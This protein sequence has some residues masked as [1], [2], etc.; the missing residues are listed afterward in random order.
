MVDVD[1]DGR[2]WDHFL[3]VLLAVHEAPQASTGFTQFELLF[4]RRPQGLL[5]MMKE[6][7]EEQ[8]SSL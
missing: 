4:K 2:N 8:P 1:E 3:Y 7:W 5:D 6:V